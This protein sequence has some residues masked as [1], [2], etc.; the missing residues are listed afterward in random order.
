M[1]LVAIS[2][3]GFNRVNRTI[4]CV[5]SLLSAEKAAD[6]QYQIQIQLTDNGSDPDEYSRLQEG[7]GN[8]TNIHLQRNNENIGF[9]A[10]HNQ[11]LEKLFSL[12]KPDFVWLLNNDCV[13]NTK[14]LPNLLQSARNQPEVGI[15]GATLLESD[16][17]TIQCAGGCFYNSWVSSYRQHGKGVPLTEVGQIESVNYDYIS[18]ASMFFPVKTLQK[19][20][21]PLPKLL[22][23]GR[24]ASGHWLNELFFL[25]FE[26]LDLMQRLQPHLSVAWCV[27]AQITHFGGHSTGTQSK[28][29]SEQ[30]EYQSSLSAL[31]FT[32][33][34]YPN[35]MWSV[36]LGRF[37][38]KSLMLAWEGDIGLIKPMI[39][40]Y[41]D[42]WHW[43]GNMNQ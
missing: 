34:Y 13:V 41:R 7:F 36:A 2:I 21:R 27:D 35:R 32:Q 14:T 24:Q 33:L 28:R 23:D 12:F 39:R 8:H 19:G 22:P 4:D 31:K 29:R 1:T 25:Y 26:E 10:G 11:N 5:Q 17:V 37:I 16:G 43:S 3:L 40:A 18:G 15:W 20:L 38:S 42:F 9:S 6:G 30:T